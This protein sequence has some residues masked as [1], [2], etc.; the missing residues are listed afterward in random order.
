MS[1]D[2]IYIEIDEASWRGHLDNIE[3][4]LNTTLTN[5]VMFRQLL[6]DVQPKLYEPHIRQFVGEIAETARRH[7]A[8]AEGFYKMIGRDPS[9]AR[10]KAGMLMARARGVA[11]EALASASGT[12][13]SWQGLQALL[14]ASLHAQSGFAVA[15]QLALAIGLREMAEAAFAIE[16]EQ[17]TGHLIL[18]ELMLEVAA[19][20]ILYKAPV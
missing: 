1:G 10:K 14:P 12:E 18:K 13:A 2:P 19:I 20:A 16:N 15:E 17:A 6:E 9:A 4:W 8:D 7:E 11:S 5:Q 3:A